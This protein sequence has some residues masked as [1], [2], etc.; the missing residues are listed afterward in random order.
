MD[1]DWIET[2]KRFWRLDECPTKVRD[3]HFLAVGQEC[4]GIYHRIWGKWM[5]FVPSHI[6][7][8]LWFMVVDLFNGGFLT[9][10]DG[11]K[12]STGMLSNLTYLTVLITIPDTGLAGLEGSDGVI[13]FHCGPIHDKANIM[14]YGRNILYYLPCYDDCQTVIHFK[15]NGQPVSGPVISSDDDIYS[16]SIACDTLNSTSPLISTH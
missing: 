7:D 5:L 9:G 16:Y 10:I 12:V 15:P 6:L 11:I 8:D 2:S 1:K 13:M 3:V 4:P 14:S